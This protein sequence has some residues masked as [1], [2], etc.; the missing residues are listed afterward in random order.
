MKK[1]LT[2]ADFSAFLLLYWNKENTKIIT[3]EFCDRVVAQDITAAAI[4]KAQCDSKDTV[5]AGLG[6]TTEAR[7]MLALQCRVLSDASEF[8]PKLWALVV[9]AADVSQPCKA[10]SQAAGDISK[11]DFDFGEFSGHPFAT[12]IILNTRTGR[13]YFVRIAAHEAV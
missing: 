7:A 11:M 10:R 12:H 4:K 1:K 3:D 5:D 6:K 9:L 13:D 2:I 8:S